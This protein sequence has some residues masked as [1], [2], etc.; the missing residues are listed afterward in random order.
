MVTVRKGYHALRRSSRTNT[1]GLAIATKKRWGQQGY[2]AR[3][4]K[5]SQGYKITGVQEGRKKRK[6]KK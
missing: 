2:T 4:Y 5:L 6:V 3:I 1:K